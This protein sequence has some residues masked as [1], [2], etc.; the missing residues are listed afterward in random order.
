MNGPISQET[1]RQH[2]VK[3]SMC[4]M[5]SFVV[6]T[7][8][9]QNHARRKLMIGFRLKFG[10]SNEMIIFGSLFEVSFNFWGRWVAAKIDFSL[11]SNLLSRWEYYLI[12][13]SLFMIHGLNQ[14]S[15]TRI[16]RRATF[17]RKNALRA[18]V[19]RRKRL[20]GPQTTRK[21]L[22]ISKICSK[23]IILLNF[24]MLAGR[25]NASGG[26]HAARGRVLET[27]GLN[28]I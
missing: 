25:T 27:P 19:Y 14:G 3:I 6:R 16:D 13:D 4:C 18:A 1:S 7:K 17:Q 23:L 26:P 11:I 15:Q 2:A 21:A 12:P 24:E 20:R 5:I 28:D 10:V 8:L 22:K 9:L